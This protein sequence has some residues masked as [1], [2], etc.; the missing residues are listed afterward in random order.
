M[1]G[2]N[3]SSGNQKWRGFCA[4][5]SAASAI[6]QGRWVAPCQRYCAYLAPVSRIHCAALSTVRRCQ[7]TLSQVP[8]LRQG[9]QSC[10]QTC[11]RYVGRRVRNVRKRERITRP[12]QDQGRVHAQRRVLAVATRRPAKPARRQ[13]DYRGRSRRFH[14]VAE[15]G[16]TDERA[17]AILAS[18]PIARHQA[19]CRY[20]CT[21]QDA[22]QARVAP[23]AA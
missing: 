7:I 18:A 20:F 15:D 9:R 21:E 23:M 2:S 5:A 3:V 1:R 12:P 13:H 17:S 4:C 22:D 8:Q 10:K 6:F 11:L 14:C 16:F 19:Y